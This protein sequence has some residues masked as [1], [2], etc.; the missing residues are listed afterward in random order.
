MRLQEPF[1]CEKGLNKSCDC[2]IIL[3]HYLTRFESVDN[4]SAES[5]SVHINWEKTTGNSKAVPALQHKSNKTKPAP[6]LH[7][8]G[9]KTCEEFQT[10]AK[11]KRR[12]KPQCQ[13]T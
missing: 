10:L 3:V 7:K 2:S 9:I 6:Q 4:S 12:K 1:L 8:G 11:C 5:C 13:T